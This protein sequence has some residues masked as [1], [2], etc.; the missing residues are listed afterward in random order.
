MQAETRTVVG[1]VTEGA[2]RTAEG[3]STVEQT[4]V[5]FERIDE[6]IERID[7]RIGEVVLCRARGRRRRGQPARRARPG[8]RRRRALDR[9]EPAGVG[10]HRA[11]ERID[12]RDRGLRAA[13]QDVAGELTG[14][15][16]RFRL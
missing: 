5:A 13:L 7:Q 3:T 2:E 10:E 1:I 15:I 16:G 8:R 9:G 4:R 11:D 14:L 12:A 6:A